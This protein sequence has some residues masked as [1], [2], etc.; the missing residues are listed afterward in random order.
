MRYRNR[1]HF[2]S[3]GCG[4]VIGKLLVK[5][6]FHFRVKDRRF[7]VYLIPEELGDTHSTDLVLVLDQHIVP[8]LVAGIAHRD[9]VWI[10]TGL[11]VPP[12]K[13]DG[14]DV[15]DGHA[16]WEIQVGG[17]HSSKTGRA[18]LAYPL[19]MDRLHPMVVALL[20]LGGFLWKSVGF[21]EFCRVHLLKV[22][23]IVNGFS[24]IKILHWKWRTIAGGVLNPFLTNSNL[25]EQVVP[26]RDAT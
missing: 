18:S 21:L 12:S 2:G 13:T 4:L 26:T 20:S 24:S 1:A 19:V 22:E 25:D 8:G 14:D 16:R 11:D 5:V 10:R 3:I 7:Q 15:F 23:D 17:T 9:A 6:G